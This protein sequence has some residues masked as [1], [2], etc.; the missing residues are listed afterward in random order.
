M[1]IFQDQL[2]DQA[3]VQL[4]K[5]DLLLLYTDGITEAMAPAPRGGG[6]RPLVGTDRLDALLLDCGNASAAACVARVR[7]GVTAFSGNAP[8]GDDQTLIAIRCAG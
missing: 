8:P 2:Y 7:A 4:E 1:G 3:A 6:P 5:G